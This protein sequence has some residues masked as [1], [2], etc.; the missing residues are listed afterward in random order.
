EFCFFCSLDKLN[1]SL[2]TG[3]NGV[4]LVNGLLKCFFCPSSSVQIQCGVPT[5]PVYEQDKSSCMEF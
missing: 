2:L 4:G 3:P 1:V 5:I